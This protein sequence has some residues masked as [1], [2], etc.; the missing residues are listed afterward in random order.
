[1]NGEKINFS[2]LVKKNVKRTKLASVRHNCPRNCLLFHIAYFW[3]SAIFCNPL[4]ISLIIA[5]SYRSTQHDSPV[6]KLQYRKHDQKR[7]QPMTTYH[8]PLLVIETES[9]QVLHKENKYFQTKTCK[10]KQNCTKQMPIYGKEDFIIA[11]TTHR[12]GTV[13]VLHNLSEFIFNQISC[14]ISNFNKGLIFLFQKQILFPTK[15]SMSM[16]FFKQYFMSKTITLGYIVRELA[17]NYYP[18]NPSCIHA[19]PQ[20]FVRNSIYITKQ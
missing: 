19:P 15:L 6:Y 17:K 8:M 1:M 12:S 13:T 4:L 20:H 11:Y 18:L 2:L 10:C 5:P 14:T 9:M 3:H 7:C 16:Q